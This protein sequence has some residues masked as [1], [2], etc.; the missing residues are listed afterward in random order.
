M[1]DSAIFVVVLTAIYLAECC[2]AVPRDGIALRAV[3]GRTHAVVPGSGLPGTA[4]TGFAWTNPLPPLGEVFVCGSPEKAGSLDGAARRLDDFRAR[5]RPLR[6]AC[7][8]LAIVLL[9]V[10]PAAALVGGLAA[11]WKPLLAVALTAH[12]AVVVAF[13]FADRALHRGGRD[14][15][16]RLLSIALA[17]PA[18]VRAVDVVSR[19]LFSGFH[20]VA[21][22]AAACDEASFRDF[23]VRSVRALRF[24]P[25]SELSRLRP[26][27]E[28][29]ER[30]VARRLGPAAT[31]LVAP[32]RES[33]SCR[34]YCP[35]CLQQYVV[36]SG[37]CPDCAGVALATF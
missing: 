32:Q 20:P 3:F 23:A 10:V 21:V 7:C 6:I 2:V 9:G 25:A 34:T 18:A 27:A 29:V 24:G 13:I 36:A 11:T 15:G 12:L 37:T 35:R 14:H 1:S 30:A 28:D 22:A 8:V 17:P 16:A 31:W 33:P 19:D 4:K 26:L 5:T